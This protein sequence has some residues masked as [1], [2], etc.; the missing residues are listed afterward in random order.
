[1]EN[2]KRILVLGAGTVGQA[3]AKRFL[4]QSCSVVIC[5]DSKSRLSGATANLPSAQSLWVADIKCADHVDVIITQAVELLG[6]LD[7]YIHTVNDY[8]FI[9][10]EDM[11]FSQWR[12]LRERCLDAAFV[13]GQRV[14][15]KMAALNCGGSILYVISDACARQDPNDPGRCATQWG[16]KGLVR[17]MAVSLGKYGVTVNAVCPHDLA[18]E[19]D[20]Q[21]RQKLSAYLGVA[22]VPKELQA[23]D[24]VAELC[25]FLVWEAVN[26]SGQALLLSNGTSFN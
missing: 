12:G 14:G 16:V 19:E 22:A 10:L 15:K 11:R 1:M 4:A 21:Q 18:T 24:E 6:G 8:D 9:P 5:D 20:D 26:V 25:A 17:S 2:Q 7:G 23:A 3:V 13:W